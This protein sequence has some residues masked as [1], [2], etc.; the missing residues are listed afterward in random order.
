VQVNKRVWNV[1]HLSYFCTA[2]PADICSVGHKSSGATCELKLV[3][4]SILILRVP[5]MKGQPAQE[6]VMDVPG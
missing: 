4:R 1:L 3:L 5:D 6:V 2:L